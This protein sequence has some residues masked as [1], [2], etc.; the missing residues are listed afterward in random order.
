MILFLGL[1]WGSKATKVGNLVTPIS[2]ANS[3]PQ[4]EVAF[5][6]ENFSSVYKRFLKKEFK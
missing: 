5:M 3:L 6:T 4:P 1:P 2:E